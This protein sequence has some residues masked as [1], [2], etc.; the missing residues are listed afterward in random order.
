[1]ISD[2]FEIT[3]LWHKEKK[4]HKL[5]IKGIGGEC[6]MRNDAQ[7]DNILDGKHGTTFVLKV[8]EDVEF[9]NVAN[10]LKSWIVVPQCKVEYKEE[11]DDSIRIG[12]DNEEEALKVF[13]FL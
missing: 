7:T 4:A 1:M 11:T 8:R 10:N 13:C 9:D 2:E 12:Y 5:R 3:T 6:I